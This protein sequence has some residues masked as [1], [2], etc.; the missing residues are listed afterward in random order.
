MESND[1]KMCKGRII[2]NKFNT[3]YILISNDVPYGKEVE[4]CQ[5]EYDF[6]IG[7]SND[8]AK[9]QDILKRAYNE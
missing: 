4:F 6:I 1:K 8:W 3:G 2:V 5:A 7:V 9:V